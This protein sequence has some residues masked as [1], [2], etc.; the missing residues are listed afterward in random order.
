MWYR[1]LHPRVAVVIVAGVER[2]N[3]MTLAWHTPVS[4]EGIVA[5]AIDKENYTYELIKK[6]REF[7]MNV[8]SIDQ[9][10]VIWTCGT[11]SGRETD[12]VKLTGIV[13]EDGVKIK[14]KHIKDSLGFLECIVEKEIDCGDHALFLARVVYWKAREFRKVWRE[15]ARVAMHVGSV[16]FCYPSK[17]RRAK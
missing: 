7:T 15:S 17:Y 8:L 12:K 1:L 5:V 14:T 16:F 9:I 11:V 10:K 3:L 4:D 6:C 13:L 2:P